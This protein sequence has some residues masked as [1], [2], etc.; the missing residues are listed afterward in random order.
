LIQECVIILTIPSP[1][2]TVKS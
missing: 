2:V 1:K